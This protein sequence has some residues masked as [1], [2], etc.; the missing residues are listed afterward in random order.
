MHTSTAWFLPLFQP[1]PS[2]RDDR[3]ELADGRS[4]RVM[5]VKAQD[6]SAER[7]FVGALSLTSRYRSFHFGLRQL[8]PE[9][10][11]AMTEVDQHEHVAFVARPEED[12]PI[13]ADARYVIRADSADAEFAIAFADDWQGAGLGRALLQRLTA[14]ARANGVQRLFGDVLLGNPSMLALVRSL[15]AQL[16]RN[17]GDS[18]VVRVEFVFSESAD[19]GVRSAPMLAS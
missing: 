1:R 19:I 2:A 12:A 4:V 10:S 5:P 17:P 11:K 18:T 7:A 14:H 15:G 13:V 6:A 16:R 3:I 8:S 9:A